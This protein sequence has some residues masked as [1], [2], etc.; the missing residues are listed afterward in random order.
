MSVHDVRHDDDDDNDVHA[1]VH[2]HIVTIFPIFSLT[3]FSCKL[4]QN[5]PSSACP[6]PAVLV[7]RVPVPLSQFRMSQSR[8][9][10]SA[11]PSPACPKSSNLHTTQVLGVTAEP[12]SITLDNIHEAQSLNDS[13]QPVIQSLQEGVKPPQGSLRDYP[14]R[15]I[16]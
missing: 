12:A 11:C 4:S 2:V 14:A 3:S 13:L 8:C 7:A 9:P 1:C 10:S 5:C 16:R 15:S 6:S